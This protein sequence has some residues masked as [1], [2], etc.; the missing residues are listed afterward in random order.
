MC[1]YIIEIIILHVLVSIVIGYM[2]TYEI[3]DLYTY[4]SNEAKINSKFNETCVYPLVHLQN[5]F[6]LQYILHEA[7][8]DKRNLTSITLPVYSTRF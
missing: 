1:L 2:P 6:L 7:N 4:R 5:N 8:Q 3:K